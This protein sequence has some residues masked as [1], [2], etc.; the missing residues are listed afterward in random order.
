[1]TD[2]YLMVLEV[3]QKQAYIFGE[4]KLH[5]NILAS[6]T[7]AYVTDP[8]FFQREFPDLFSEEE[9]LIYSGG[10]HTLLIFP[11]EITAKAFARKVSRHV[12]EKLPGL[13]LFIK[14]RR[15]ETNAKTEKPIPQW[16][17]SS[18]LRDLEI[19]KSLRKA[20]FY[21]TSFGLEQASRLT[22]ISSSAPDS[23]FLS[24]NRKYNSYRDKISSRMQRC[25]E[26]KV[27]S[28][29]LEKIQE[30]FEFCEKLE[31]LGGT[32]GDNN[33][34][35]VVHIDGNQMGARVQELDHT[36]SEKCDKIPGSREEFDFWRTYKKAFSDNIDRQFKEAFYEMLDIVHAELTE[37]NLKSLSLKNSK[38]NKTFFPVRKIILA[39]DD[40]CFITEGRIGLECAVQY[41]RCL[42]KKQ[43]PIDGK[44]YSACAG[45]AIV[46]QK[47]PFYRAYDMAE[48]LCSNAKRIMAKRLDRINEQIPEKNP[49]IPEGSLSAIDWHIEYGEL[50][51]DLEDI[52]EK[53]TDSKGNPICARPYQITPSETY[54]NGFSEYAQFQNLVLKLQDI[55]KQQELS[56]NSQNNEKHG[57]NSPIANTG[58]ARS[59][60]KNLR[61]AIKIGQ[62]EAE[63][64]CQINF[65]SEISEFNSWAE[66]FDALEA[67][68]L[69]LPFQR[70]F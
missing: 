19:K 24:D 50:I 57:N 68:D 60:L 1:M 5:N 30:D 36:I 9:N 6:D 55:K 32:K 29:H 25:E 54:I 7:I 18:L 44:G 20:S 42:E 43:N 28:S 66:L 46:H 12:L 33:F 21:Q 34:I 63:R 8:V 15:Y 17:M 27:K 65:L 52:R 3:S 40:V 47:Y 45:V 11:D 49:K 69:F 62:E 64:Y 38:N 23:E 22:S 56:R 31:M 13:E 51:G 4:K 61:N 26:T 35:A 53:Y 37:G 10:G 48:Q 16:N 58:I 70:R 59:K 67:I 39:G 41:I 14:I 2:K